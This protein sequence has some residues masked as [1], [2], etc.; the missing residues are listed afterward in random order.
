M[1]DQARQAFERLSRLRSSHA[2]TPLAVS[3]CTRMDNSTTAHTTAHMRRC[4]YELV[5]R[6]LIQKLRQMLPSYELYPGFCELIANHL[7]STMGIVNF[8]DCGE[9][10]K[11]HSKQWMK[12]LNFIQKF[13]D[14]VGRKL[15]GW[16]QRSS[17]EKITCCV[18]TPHRPHKAHD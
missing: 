15:L 2:I 5:R 7:V 1:E 17:L 6:I 9:T 8:L 4:G 16:L 3:P 14:A 12:L 13:L 10:P 18:G 11:Q